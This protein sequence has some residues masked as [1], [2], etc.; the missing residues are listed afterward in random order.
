MHQQIR[1]VN[2]DVSSV[3]ENRPIKDC[4]GK[5]HMCKNTHLQFFFSLRLFLFQGSPQ[6][7]TAFH[8]DL[9]FVTSTLTPTTCMSSFIASIN[10]PFGRPLGLLPGSCI[11][12]ILLPM[13]PLSLLCT[14]P[15]HLSLVSLAFSP[16]LPV[17]MQR[18]KLT[19]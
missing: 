19:S 1:H 10:L 3:G 13:S 6:R 5:L 8:F 11:S 16:S 15:K 2:A 7:I 4:T 18:L 9:F 14:C 12:S 17:Y